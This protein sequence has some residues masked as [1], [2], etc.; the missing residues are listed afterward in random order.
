MRKYHE[1]LSKNY[2]GGCERFFSPTGFLNKFQKSI[3]V[4]SQS[5]R[6]HVFVKTVDEATTK[7]EAAITGK[8]EVFDL[9]AEPGTGKT[10][11]LPFRFPTKRVIVALPTPFDAWNAFNMATGACSLK[12]K[13]LS[14]GSTSSNVVYTDS[15]MAA[16]ALL[17]NYLE[18]DIMVVDEC[19]SDRGVSKFLSEVK[20][21]GKLLI[22]MSASHGRHQAGLSRAF[23]VTESKDMPDVREG[24]R[25]VVDFVIEKHHGRSLLLAPDASVAKSLS[26]M[27][28]GSILITVETPLDKLAKSMTDQKAKAL[29]VSDD[30]CGRAINL[31]LDI[32]FDCQLVTEYSNMRV[33][34]P[35]EALQRKGRVGRNRE[36]WYYSPGLTPVN[37]LPNDFDIYRNNVVRAFAGVPQQGHERLKV[38][39]TEIDDLITAD[40]EPYEIS[41]KNRVESAV[42]TSSSESGSPPTAGYKTPDNRNSADMSSLTSTEVE[43]RV[44][45]PSWLAYFSGYSSPVGD[46]SKPTIADSFV[47]TNARGK[48]A[49]ARRSS[50]LSGSNSGSSSSG[51]SVDSSVA[52]QRRDHRGVTLH[53][54]APVLPVAESAPYAAVRRDRVSAINPIDLP[55]APPVMDLTD[56]QY[57]MD[58]PSLLRDRLARGGDLPTIVPYGNWRHTSAGGLGTD[59]FRRLDDMATK[60]H[61]FDDVE[62]EVIIRAWNKLVAQAWV[63]RTPGLSNISDTQRF[64]FCLR[65]FQSY[66]IMGSVG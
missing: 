1:Y 10:S 33:V 47:I 64:E 8:Q 32:E 18:Y 28:P 56:V 27:L 34:T 45:A 63:R 38:N 21:P 20:A 5:T 14:L 53:R 51:R 40:R 3:E 12:L 55:Q 4:K 46:S 15:Y 35:S 23:R 9:T 30:S 61:T 62:F 43:R 17:S 2:D 48:K 11:V 42:L 66:F 22:R 25:N 31:N 6:N 59:W 36:G 19:D 39:E 49:F 13:G 7:L 24:F 44:R 26:K 54:A 16:H 60:D 58:W 65:Y 37:K 41:H 29:F 52:L 50:S 57:D